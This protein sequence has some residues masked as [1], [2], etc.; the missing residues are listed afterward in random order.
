MKKL[1]LSLMI[2]SLILF[3]SCAETYKG[4]ILIGRAD[5]DRV[6]A[7]DRGFSARANLYSPSPKAIEF[8]KSYDKPI[9]IEVIYGSWCRDSKM[10]VPEFI[11][12]MEKAENPNIRVR[13]IGVDRKKNDPERLAKKRKIE[14]VPTFIV[15]QKG[16]ELGR[17]IETPEISIEDDLV[18]ILAE[19]GSE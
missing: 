14:R 17:I 5:L 8:L 15:F 18:K 16:K 2:S 4:P 11:K 7:V 19:G 3:A 6:L 13:Y 1:L 9:M 10:H 12:V